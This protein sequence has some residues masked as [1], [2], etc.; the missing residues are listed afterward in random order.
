MLAPLSPDDIA[1]VMR[2]ERLP[3]YDAF[4]GRWEAEE[5]AA[6]MASPQARYF[7]LRSPGGLEG[8]A[9]LQ[10][11]DTPSVLLRRIAVEGVSRGVGGRLLQGVMDWVFHETAAE[12]LR[13]DVL[14][15]NARARRAYGRE[16]F[17]DDGEAVI[18]GLPHILMSIP[19]GRWT[20]LRAGAA[21]PG[22]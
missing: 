5:H 15:E 21:A 16:G 17:R 2:I 11:L 6:E 8:F 3:G 13:L 14:P 18:H 20:A 7:G 19:R 1:E 10:E 4:V 12:A 9:I 22:G